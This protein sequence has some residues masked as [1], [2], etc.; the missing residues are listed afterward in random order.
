MLSGVFAAGLMIQTAASPRGQAR[1]VSGAGQ[2]TTEITRNTSRGD[3][4]EA[5]NETRNIRFAPIA[6]KQASAHLSS[7]TKNAAKAPL[8]R[9][10]ASLNLYG[11]V[12]FNNTWT[13]YNK[14]GVYKI[15]VS[16]GNALEMLFR[17][18]NPV[19]Y[20]FYDGDGLYYSM[21]EVA[22]GSYV[23]GYDLYA[24][25]TAT[26]E[27]VR[28]I[29]FDDLPIRA[30]DVAYDPLSQRVY[31][32]FSGDYYGEPYRFWG[33]LDLGARNAVRI[34]DMNFSLRAVAIDKH[35]NAYGIDLA[36]NL[37]KINKSTGTFTAVGATGCPALYYMSSAAY[38]DKDGSIILA[39]CNDEKSGLVEIDPVS[40][41]SEVIAE[42]A[43]GDEVIGLYM[44]AQAPDNAPAAPSMTVSC[45][46][47]SMTADIT[48]VMP[49]KLYA[50]ADAAG[51]QM[52]YKIYADG[53]E[54][55][56]GTAEAGSTVS[57]SAVIAG[58]GMHTFTAVATNDAGTR[59][60]RTAISARV[61]RQLP[62]APSSH[63][64]TVLSP[65]HGSR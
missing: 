6:G 23:V 19:V 48:L 53:T 43:E 51:T 41:H 9:V 46:D 26:N 64:P 15:P 10:S 56:A 44:P 1:F 27:L 3:I 60:G 30:T 37:Y 5:D 17:T 65:S 50:G 58:S 62:P 25:D 35:G 24:F 28:T 31:G 57:K 49:V 59:P 8:A 38:N 7:G 12:I 47:G 18:P 13:D 34:A 39:F 16:S 54:I 21:H 22:Y 42:F 11:T 4:R 55:F 14:T 32:C 45:A 29:E 20:A 52:G 63:M 36:G 40:A 2:K 61:L 33:Y